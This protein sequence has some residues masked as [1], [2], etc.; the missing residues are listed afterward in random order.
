[1]LAHFSTLSW[2]F[3]SGIKVVKNRSIFQHN[4]QLH[5]RYFLRDLSQIC[6][7]L[8]YKQMHSLRFLDVFCEI[9]SKKVVK[10]PY[11]W[12]V[13]TNLFKFFPQNLLKQ[14]LIPIH[15][16]LRIIQYKWNINYKN[17]ILTDLLV[18]TEH[19]T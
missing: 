15:F 6:L 14:W 8:L 2:N 4:F 9:S 16:S 7:Q 13:V 11:L 17:N 10:T 3:R 5:S 18:S 1:M 19:S 12:T